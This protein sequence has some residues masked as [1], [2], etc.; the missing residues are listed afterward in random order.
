MLPLESRGHDCLKHAGAIYRHQDEPASSDEP[1]TKRRARHNAGLSR[2]R[3][4]L[5]PRAVQLAHGSEELKDVWL[6]P[7]LSGDFTGTMCLTEPQC[8]SDLGQVSTRAAPR[9]D[10]SY[11]ISGTKI[12]ISCGEHDLTDNIVHCV[13][14]RLPDAPPGTSSATRIERAAWHQ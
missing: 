2:R 3:H 9:D 13:L 1:A 12:F 10:G 7:L 8:G 4:L 5:D 11:S 6:P 14:A